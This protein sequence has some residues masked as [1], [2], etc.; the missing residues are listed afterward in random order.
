[1]GHQGQPAFLPATLIGKGCRCP[2]QLHT[3]L[4]TPTT[5]LA[6]HTVSYPAPREVL[7]DLSNLNE[8]SLGGKK[9]P[10]PLWHHVAARHGLG[11]SLTGR[12]CKSRGSFLVQRSLIGCAIDKFKILYIFPM[13]AIS[14]PTWRFGIKPPNAN[15][16]VGLAC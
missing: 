1:M 9:S 5:S 13:Y 7:W 4:R 12:Q 2:I 8:Y 15:Q 6:P 14:R 11:I 10:P 3:V 16:A